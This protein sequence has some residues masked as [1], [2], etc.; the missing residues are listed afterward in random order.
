MTTADHSGHDDPFDPLVA[1]RF[2]LLER[3]DPPQ[4][5]LTTVATTSPVAVL[6]RRRWNR[7]RVLAVAAALIVVAVASAAVLVSGGQR[8]EIAA[9]EAAD[10]TDSSIRSS[11]SQTGATTTVLEVVGTDD[12][13]DDTS[14]GTDD[15]AG[16]GETAPAGSGEAATT[17]STEA[18]TSSTE[19]ETTPSTT[20]PSNGTDPTSTSVS[21]IPEEEGIVTLTGVVTAV[22]SDCESHLVLDDGDEVR[23]L[24][25]VSCDGGSWIEI[26]GTRIRSSS[27]Y[28]A[29]DQAWD[30]HWRGLQPGV[31]ATVTAAGANGR[32]QLNLDCPVCGIAVG[33][34]DRRGNGN[35]NGNGLGNGNGNGNGLGNGDGLG[36]GNGKTPPGRA[37][38]PGATIPADQ[39]NELG[40]PGGGADK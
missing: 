14:D 20:A 5:D 15:G 31:R 22:F 2:E 26:D 40:G 3:L 28:T 21:L 23:S 37:S 10:S 36:N 33:D 17:G 4:L 32:G 7:G 34:D 25:P 16:D 11:G 1:E 27:G 30:R 8:S 18:P 6:D 29:S 9:S 12:S 13:N 35:G 38:G 19:T 39:L 24:G